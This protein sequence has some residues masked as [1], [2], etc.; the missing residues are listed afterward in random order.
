M[1]RLVL[2]IGFCL[3]V[4]ACLRADEWDDL[5]AKSKA[6]DKEMVAAKAAF[7]RNLPSLA[8]YQKAK[9][10]LDDC[11]AKINDLRGAK[12]GATDKELDA[13]IKAKL[14]AQNELQ[15]ISSELEAKDAGV[16]AVNKKISDIDARLEA[17]NLQRQLEDQK[18]H[19]QADQERREKLDKYRAVVNRD[20]K[21]EERKELPSIPL[22]GDET[23]LSE[24]SASPEKFMNRSF[25]VCGHVKISD[26]YNYGY[27][28]AKATHFAF[29]IYAVTADKRTAGRATMY[30][31]RKD[32]DDLVEILAKREKYWPDAPWIMRVKL[33][34][35][36]EYVK[37]FN[38]AQELYSLLDWQFLGKDG[39]W[40]PWHS[41]II[42]P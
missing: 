17:L 18:R 10:T 36:P 38:Q 31:P 9:K 39:V 29:A 13:A 27:S 34:I 7:R 4:T 21:T 42:A 41:E 26:Y 35:D 19:A 28:D 12:A 22:V 5:V 37:T 16:V 2:A 14:A 40:S 15:K 11:N 33:K 23:G 25:I 20:F 6:L 3:F 24:V 8:E 30:L 32:G 1:S